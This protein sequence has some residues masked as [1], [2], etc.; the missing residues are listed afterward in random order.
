M[1]I[2]IDAMGG[3]HAPLE[4]I[5]GS[6]TAA[7]QYGFTPVLVGQE[8]AMLA[9]LRE[10]GSEAAPANAELVNTTEIIDMHDDPAN[11]VRRKKDSSMSVALDLLKEGKVDAMV[12]AGST[13]ALLVGATLVVKRIRGIRRAALAPFLP[14]GEGKTLLIDCGANVECTPEYLLQFALMGSL[15]CRIA[16][17]VKEP[18]VGLLNNGAED[19]KGGPLQKEAY[20]LL[21]QA[22]EEGKINFIGNIEG[23]DVCL[24]GCDVA[25]SDGFT[26][27]VMMKGIEGMGLLIKDSLKG[28]FYKNLRTKLAGLLVKKEM[29]AFKKMFDVSEVGGTILL[30]IS[31]PVIKAH[32]SSNAKAFASSLRQAYEAVNSGI[33]DSI[34]REVQKTESAEA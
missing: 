22:G 26:G 4:I 14:S 25:V 2:A 34:A 8:E 13:G 6:L 7:K 17:G 27:N 31:K 33:C 10:L 16:A 5:K 9:A 32:G 29:D 21:K 18:R 28:V 11:A 1:K 15:Y 20:Q 30:G 24:G 19:T 3:D 12:S 23:R